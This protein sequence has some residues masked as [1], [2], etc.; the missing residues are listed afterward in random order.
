[1]NARALLD[2]YNERVYE[3]TLAKE[4]AD[5]INYRV[6]LLEIFGDVATKNAIL[7]FENEIH[8]W[9]EAFNIDEANMYLIDNLEAVKSAYEKAVATLRE[10]YEKFKA[11]VEGIGKVNVN[12]KSNIDTA[13]AAYEVVNEYVDVNILLALDDENTIE[14]LFETLQHALERYNRLIFLVD[15]IRLEIGR[16]HESDPCVTHDDIAQLN[17]LVD[18]LLAFEVSINVLDT[19]KVDYVIMLEKARLMPHKNE[20]FSEIKDTYDAYYLVANNDR[21]IIISLVE[22]KDLT[23]NAIEEANSVEE[24]REI[25]EKAKEAFKICFE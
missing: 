7:N 18:E 19:E 3:L 20:A 4:S 9:A 12:S 11:A 1:M 8:A 14:S 15:S 5:E 13:F 17:A 21:T 24:I 16:M 6:S 2:G 25:V 22:I 10:L 23:L